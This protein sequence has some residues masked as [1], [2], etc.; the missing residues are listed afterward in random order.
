MLEWLSTIFH[1]GTIFASM[2][3]SCNGEGKTE[4]KKQLRKLKRIEELG[5][6]ESRRD[7]PVDVCTKVG[8]EEKWTAKWEIILFSLILYSIA[9]RTP[10]LVHT[11]WKLK[12]K[13]YSGL[14]LPEG[15]GGAH[16]RTTDC[17]VWCFAILCVCSLSHVWL[18]ATPRT[19]GHQVPLSMMFSRQEFCNGLP[20]FPPGYLPDPGIKPTLPCISG[21]VRWVLCH[22]VKW[23][24]SHLLLEALSPHWVR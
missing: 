10:T 5:S 2:T 16:W 7:V 13:E 6:R 8:T 24:E 3:S 23:L 18:C 22:W 11:L 1:R 14:S 17:L 19:V 4:K 21:N 15:Q 12:A 9:P 20:F